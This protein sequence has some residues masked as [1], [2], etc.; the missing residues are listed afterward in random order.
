MSPVIESD[1]GAFCEQSRLFVYA[2]MC[3]YIAIVSMCLVSEGETCNI[4][5]TT[6]L[7]MYSP[8]FREKPSSRLD[9][10]SLRIFAFW[11]RNTQVSL[12]RKVHSCRVFS[13][14][15][16]CSVW[17][18]L[19]TFLCFSRG[20]PPLSGYRD[21]REIVSFCVPRSFLHSLDG[22]MECRNERIKPRSADKRA[23]FILKNYCDG[24]STF[25]PF[26]PPRFSFRTRALR[27]PPHF[28]S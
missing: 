5:T 27:I 18:S 28:L 13:R 11:K 25:R 1:E 8:L 21:K 24:R 10:S 23:L 9:I 12:S 3:I 26:F 15:K 17:I 20:T 22:Q 2:N 19:N 4:A 16:K 7:F 14:R 6:K